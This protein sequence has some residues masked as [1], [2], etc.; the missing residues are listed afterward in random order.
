MTVYAELAQRYHPET[1]VVIHEP[2]TMNARLGQRVSVEEWTAFVREAAQVIKRQSPATRIG[3]GGLAS[4][5]DYFDAFLR[6]PDVDVLTIDLYAIRDLK[7]YNAMIRAAR[8]AGKPV[9]I[10]ETWRPPYFEPRPGMTLDTASMKN[11]GNR[12]FEALDSQWLRTM[13]AYAQA[14]HLEAITPVW[15]FAFFAYVDGGGDA[16]DPAYVRAVIDSILRGE[17]TTTFRNIPRP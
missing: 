2:S 9:Y 16:D 10:E 11:I 17:R 8:A 12:A 3:A 6:L 7:R 1:F 4:E 15:A 13:T 14:N 5:R